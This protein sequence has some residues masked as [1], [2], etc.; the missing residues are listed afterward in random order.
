MSHR[1]AQ[2]GFLTFISSTFAIP[3]GFDFAASG[4]FPSSSGKECDFNFPSGFSGFAVPTGRFNRHH[5]HHGCMPSGAQ[6]PQV[7][8]S[9]SGAAPTDA[10]AAGSIAAG[11]DGAYTSTTMVMV[12]VTMTE[13]GSAAATSTTADSVDDSSTTDLSVVST[14]F[15]SSVAPAA[16]AAASSSVQL[17]QARISHSYPVSVPAASPVPSPVASPVA[18]S[19]AAPVATTAPQA[20]ATSA[21]ATNGAKRGV[22]YNLPNLVSP[23]IGQKFISWAY[24]WAS[25]SSGVPSG[26]EYVPML[27]GTTATFTDKWETDAKAGIAAGASALLGFNEPDQVGQAN[28]SPSVAATAYQTYMSDMFGGQT[29]RLGSPAVTN[30]PA[31]MG[32]AWLSDFMSACTKCQID[33]VVSIPQV[34]EREII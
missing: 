9:A 34:D 32:L 12:T 27:W 17:Q 29:V 20:T 1:L 11:T 4:F 5:G 31:P 14:I 28:V 8:G 26:V 30:G 24:N 6:S 3:L 21:P 16:S 15:A 19:S 22:A 10:A 23:F 33:F 25:T 7:A 2:L 18:G 13:D